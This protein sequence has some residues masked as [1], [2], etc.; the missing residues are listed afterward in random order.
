MYR[1]DESILYGY[2]RY[3]RHLPDPQY[4]LGF[5]FLS[6]FLRLRRF[7]Y[8]SRQDFLA[9]LSEVEIVINPCHAYYALWAGVCNWGYRMGYPVPTDYPWVDLKPTLTCVDN[10]GF[11]NNLTVGVLYQAEERT[12]SDEKIRVRD[13]RG[14]LR[15]F[16]LTCFDTNALDEKQRAWRILN[17]AGEPVC[18]SPPPGF[19]GPPK[20]RIVAGLPHRPHKQ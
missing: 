3:R 20:N 8:V 2:F 17:D 12:A 4:R 19:E 15:R 18:C 7:R 9:F 16:P 13:D 11:S 5:R 14:R 6:K 10:R 1:D